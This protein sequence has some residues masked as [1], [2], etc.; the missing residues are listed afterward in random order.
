MRAYISLFT[1]FDKRN[2]WKLSII[3]FVP[4]K[5]KIRVHHKGNIFSKGVQLLV[6]AD[7][8]VIEHM[9]CTKR[10]VY[11]NR[12]RLCWYSKT[13]YMFSPYRDMRH[14][15]SQTTTGKY[16]LDVAN[17]YVYLGSAIISKNN[18]SHEVKW[19]ITL[20]NR[21]CCGLSSQLSAE[22]SPMVRNY[23]CK[24]LRN[25]FG[26]VC[27]DN[28]FHLRKKKELNDLARLFDSTKRALSSVVWTEVLRLDEIWHTGC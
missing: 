11:N 4:L 20:A 22:T 1:S 12:T 10:N 3:C 16:I 28:D 8:V 15:A 21:F 14:I 6:C 24:S 13:K 17:E 25:I 27:L 18:V 19:K 7:D 23:R 26:P 5:G 9:R 2:D